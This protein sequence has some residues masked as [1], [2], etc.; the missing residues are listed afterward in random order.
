MSLSIIFFIV[1]VFILVVFLYIK[2]AN[3][4]IQKILFPFF[5][6]ILYRTKTGL[7]LIEKWGSKYREFFRFLGL[8]CIGI[9]FFYMFIAVYNIGASY[10]LLIKY[11]FKPVFPILVPG[12]S[13]P[14]E[15]VVSFSTWIIAIFVIATVHEFAHGVVAAANKVKVK[16]TGFGFLSVI[17]PLFPAFF[18]EPDEKNLRKQSDV[19]QYSIFAAGPVANLLVYL[20]FIFLISFALTPLTEK[21]SEPLGVSMEAINQDYPAGKFFDGRVTVTKVNGAAVNDSE[22]F[23]DSVTGIVPGQNIV[24]GI[25]NGSTYKL[26]AAKDPDN[27]EK[28]YLGVFGFKN[29]VNWHNKMLGGFLSWLI[30]L[31]RMLALLNLIVALV[32]LMPIFITDGARMIEVAASKMFKNK[33]TAKKVWFIVNILVVVLVVGSIFLPYLLKWLI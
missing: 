21:Y 11:L 8:V 14:G 30:S 13:I 28:G 27:P 24:L 26:V 22:Q 16:N 31:S 6:V 23:A 19:V 29:E 5:Y 25:L 32:N 2:R 20:L 1:F 12:M 4:S 9:G 18:V 3:L 17:V 33:M 7:A 10:Y 15:G